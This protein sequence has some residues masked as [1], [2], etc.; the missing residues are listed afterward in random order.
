MCEFAILYLVRLGAAED[1][2]ARY[3]VDLS[4]A[5]AFGEDAVL[6]AAEQFG[7]IVVTPAHEGVGHPRH[8]RVRETFAA[9]VARGFDPHQA[10]VEAILHIALEDAKSE[11]RRVGKECVSTCRSRWWPCY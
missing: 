5:E 8:R 10:R 3:D 2:L 7:G 9:A 1:E 4:A 6:D 11:E